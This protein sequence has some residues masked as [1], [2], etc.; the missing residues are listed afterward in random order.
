MVVFILDLPMGVIDTFFMLGVGALSSWTLLA[1]VCRHL[2][3]PILMLPF[4]TFKQHP[5]SALAGVQGCTALLFL[6]NGCNVPL[7]FDYFKS[8]NIN[9]AL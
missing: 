1:F 5:E 8:I 2:T 6:E 3:F 4:P 9:F 7:N